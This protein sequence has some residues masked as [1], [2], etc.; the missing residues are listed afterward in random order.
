[1]FSIV[2][3][4]NCA[5]LQTH[6]VCRTIGIETGSQNMVVALSIILLSFKDPFVSHGMKH[7]DKG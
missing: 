3:N 5:F 1:M 4:I 6:K 7:K 2:I